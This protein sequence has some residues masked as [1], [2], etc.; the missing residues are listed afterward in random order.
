MLRAAVIEG[1]TRRQA[2]QA[3]H[4][5]FIGP[6]RFGGCACG[7]IERVACRAMRIFMKMTDWFVPRRHGRD[8]GRRSGRGFACDEEGGGAEDLV[9]AGVDERLDVDRVGGSTVMDKADIDG[10]CD[11]EHGY[12][13]TFGIAA[14]FGE[15]GGPLLPK[16]QD[17][18]Q[19]NDVLAIELAGGSVD[20]QPRIVP[21]EACIEGC[22]RCHAAP[23]T[24]GDD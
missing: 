5:E 8:G 10:E 18:D 24:F 14:C 20:L 9:E 16:I 6:A 17:F 3:R 4:L 22:H 12:T 7:V 21:T 2:G 15:D 11:T 19:K 1:V 13:S 23:A